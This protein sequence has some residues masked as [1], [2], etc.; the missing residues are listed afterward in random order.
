MWIAA[1]QRGPLS[2]NVTK[3]VQWV[4]G[5][6]TAACTCFPICSLNFP[7]DKFLVCAKCVVPGAIFMLSVEY[8]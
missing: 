3:C 1:V 5:S 8:V 7:C 2:R 6:A 4:A